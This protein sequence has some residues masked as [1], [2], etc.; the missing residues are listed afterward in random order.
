MHGVYGIE[1]K[2]LRTGVLARE[3]SAD[4]IMEALS[5]RRVYATID[6]ALHLEFWLND[7]MMGSALAERP[8]GELRAR[9]FAN[10]PT[11][12][13]VS[14]VEIHGGKYDSNGGESAMLLDLPVGPEV[15]IVEGA[16]EN[17]YD[18]YYVA[19]YRE[20]AE[21]ARAFSAPI[22]MDNE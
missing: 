7:A 4:A 22:W 6:P 3:L 14:R 20:G 17:G 19:A 2:T 8:E 9:I 15:R 13:V 16:V 18:F 11:G 1:N 5:A 21:T 10:D 12:N